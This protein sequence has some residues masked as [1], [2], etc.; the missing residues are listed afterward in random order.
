MYQTMGLH[1]ICIKKKGVF[2]SVIGI[3]TTGYRYERKVNLLIN[4]ILY[5]KLNNNEFKL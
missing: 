4:L 3:Q 2:F 1:N 5:T